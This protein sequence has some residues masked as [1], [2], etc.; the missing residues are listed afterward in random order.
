MKRTIAV[1]SLPILLGLSGCRPTEEV[2]PV[3]AAKV[4]HETYLKNNATGYDWFANASDGYAGVPLILLRSLPDLAPEIW[5]KP[6]EQFSSFGFL[7]NQIKPGS[8]LPLGLSWD[9]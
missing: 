8:P 1:I 7:P 3:A 5:G 4:A 2:S 6:E 9:A